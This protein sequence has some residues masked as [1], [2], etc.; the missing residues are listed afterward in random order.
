VTRKEKKDE[1]SAIW[2]GKAMTL[3]KNGRRR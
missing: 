1:Q 2:V 3:D